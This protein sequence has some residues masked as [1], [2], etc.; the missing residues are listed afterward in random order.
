MICKTRGVITNNYAEVSAGSVVNGRLYFPNKQ[1]LQYV[2]DQIKDKEEEDIAKYIDDKGI[3]SLR[4]VIT[5]ENEKLIA[6]KMSLRMEKL[7]LNK[8]FMRVRGSSVNN[9]EELEDDIDDLE[10]IVGDDAYGAFLNSD[11]EIQVGE[12]I[13][14]Y[15]DVGLFV[16]KDTK[17][18]ELTKYLEVRKISDNLLY[19]TESSIKESFINNTTV[20]NGEDLVNLNENIQYYI[21]KPPKETIIP[22]KGGVEMQPSNPYPN[23]PSPN[24]PDANVRNYINN[25]QNC[26]P[27]SGLFGNI[28]GLNKVCVDRYESRRRVKVKAFNYNYYL[29]Y[30][31]GIKVK[32]Q[33]KGRVSWRKEKVDEIRLGVAGVQFH[34]DYSNHFASNIPQNRITTIYN[35]NSRLD[36]DASVKWQPGFYPYSYTIKNYSI[37]NY[38]QILKDNIYIEDI[39]GLDIH[40]SM[41]NNALIDKAIYSAIKAGNKHLT[42]EYL[43]KKFWDESLDYLR[44][45]WVKLGKT[46]PE[47]NNITYSLNIPELSKVIIKKVLYKTEYNVS[48]VDKTFDWGF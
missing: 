43:N 27:R 5:L 33:Y 42:Y 16:V 45:T 12:Q 44:K 6:E 3:I 1:S 37:Q 13:Y 34:Y 38:P 48:K 36:F 24:D 9:R 15:T 40:S 39:L 47:N 32:H 19:P 7:K 31:T 17:Y 46:I 26:S 18:N 29:V 28:F 2:Y 8:R 4:P 35:N 23:I 10:E 25:L 30:H 14:K 22:I 20:G 41:S 11:A 21:I